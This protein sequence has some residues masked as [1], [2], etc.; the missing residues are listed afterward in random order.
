MSDAK[1]GRA[2]TILLGKEI[3]R[4]YLIKILY[5]LKNI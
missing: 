1:L 2:K 3:F 5:N 4:I